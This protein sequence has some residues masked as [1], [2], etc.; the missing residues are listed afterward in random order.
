MACGML[1]V[2]IL[3]Y[4]YTWRTTAF[5]VM[6]PMVVLFIG[7]IQLPESPY[8]LV[9]DDQYNLAQKSLEFFR[10]EAYDI[11]EEMNEIV[12]KRDSKRTENRTSTLKRMIDS[13]KSFLKPFSCIGILY[14]LGSW[15]GFNSILVYMDT[16]L[17]ESGS[18]GIGNVQF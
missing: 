18:S 6:I 7:L 5:L 9:E 10:G 17:K 14:L 15:T 11:T 12:E 4:F 1:T 13:R 2:W 3:G 16:I 8:W